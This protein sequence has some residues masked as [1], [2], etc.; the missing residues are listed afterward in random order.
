MT[1]CSPSP[2]TVQARSVPVLLPSG[3]TWTLLSHHPPPACP[4]HRHASPDSGFSLLC[5]LCLNHAPLCTCLLPAAARR[6]FK[7]LNLKKP[8]GKGHL[9]QIPVIL[10]AQRRQVHRD[11]S[12]IGV[13]GGGEGMESADVMG[14]GFLLGRRDVLELAAHH[15]RCAKCHFL[16]STKCTCS[17]YSGHKDEFH[18]ISTLL[19]LKQTKLKPITLD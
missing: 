10:N 18:V 9:L 1:P 19:Q 7:K 15:C 6:A 11:R 2:A 8:D 3:C 5:P 17:L 14:A 12:H 16:A 4:G 13:M